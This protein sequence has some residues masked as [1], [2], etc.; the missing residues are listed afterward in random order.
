MAAK[1]QRRQYRR[2]PGLK[3]AANELSVTYSHL[4]RV[5]TRERKTPMLV[6]YRAWKRQQQTTP[7]TPNFTSPNQTQ[8]T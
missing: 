6:L 7:K 1:C 8:Q 3:E 5:I 2:R 4:R